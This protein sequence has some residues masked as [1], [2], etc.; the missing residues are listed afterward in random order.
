MISHNMLIILRHVSWDKKNFSTTI[1]LGGSMAQLENGF[2]S[3]TIPLVVQAA[4]P[5]SPLPCFGGANAIP[6]PTKKKSTLALVLTVRSKV[7]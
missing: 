3:Q 2:L 7:Q 4:F 1:S 5:T 6:C